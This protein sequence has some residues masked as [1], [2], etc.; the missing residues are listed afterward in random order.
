S[1]LSTHANLGTLDTAQGLTQL[2]TGNALV[3]LCQASVTGLF[4]AA[5][6]LAVSWFSPNTRGKITAENS[7]LLCASSVITSIIANALLATLI[8]LVVVVSRK[9]RVNPGKCVFSSR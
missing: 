6:S 3:V 8:I 1:R 7:L 9:W 4:A 2:L 5:A